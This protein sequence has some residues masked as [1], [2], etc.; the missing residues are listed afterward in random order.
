MQKIQDKIRQYKI[1][2]IVR[3]I[4]EEDIIPLAHGLYEGGIRLLEITF[5]QDS[6]T[7]REDTAAAIRKVKKEFGH[8]M[9]IGAGTVLN[10]GQVDAAV[11]AGAE[12][13]LSAV[14]NPDVI[15]YAKNLGVGVIPGAMSP[16]E[17]LTA[18]DNGADFVKVFPAG[19]LGISYIKSVRAP[20]SHIPMIAVGGVHVGNMAEFF[21]AGMAGVGV[22]SNLANPHLVKKRDFAQITHLSRL[23]TSQLQL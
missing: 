23:Y 10:C 22:G 14:T 6:P 5:S 17:I 8:A 21:E 11:G 13:I 19:S 4:G 3:G 20:L 18:Y 15:R 1:I 16:T 12:F 2:S 9:C 7:G